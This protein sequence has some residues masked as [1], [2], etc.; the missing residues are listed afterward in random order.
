MQKPVAC[1]QRV[2]CR[3]AAGVV[4]LYSG[5]PHPAHTAAKTHSAAKIRYT[6]S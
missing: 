2:A 6:R 5:T 3:K 1:R 4:A